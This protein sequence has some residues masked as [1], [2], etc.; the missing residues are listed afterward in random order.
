MSDQPHIV[1]PRGRPAPIWHLEFLHDQWCVILNEDGSEVD[2]FETLPE[3]TARMSALFE[4]GRSDERLRNP[5]GPAGVPS[6]TGPDPAPNPEPFP[7]ADFA[8]PGAGAGGADG[9]DSP[10]Q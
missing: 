2:A 1:S 5:G 3:A 8:D 9:G 6:S 10:T 7:L 4:E